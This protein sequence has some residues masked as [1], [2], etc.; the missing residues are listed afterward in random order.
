MLDFDF[1]YA[2]CYEK[3]G[4]RE[5]IRHRYAEAQKKIR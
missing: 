3:E 1:N 5:R 2:L 4:G